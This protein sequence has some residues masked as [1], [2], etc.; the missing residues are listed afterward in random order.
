MSRQ[1]GGNVRFRGPGSLWKTSWKGSVTLSQAC[2]VQGFSI[3]ADGQF[4]QNPNGVLDIAPASGFWLGVVVGV[5]DPPASPVPIARNGSAANEGWLLEMFPQN[6]VGGDPGVGFRFTVYDGS[7]P[8]AVV[9]TTAGYA[10]RTAGQTQLY[11]A[12][13]IIPVMVGLEPPSGTHTHGRA[14]GGWGGATALSAAYS[15]TSPLLLVGT[16]STGAY[17]D[18]IFGIVGGQ[19]QW[20]ENAGEFELLSYDGAWQLAMLEADGVVEVPDQSGVT[21]FQN[22]HG[23]RIADTG[24]QGIAAP[25]PLEDFVG[26]EELEYGNTGPSAGELTISCVSPFVFSPPSA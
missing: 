11:G 17:P 8:A 6:T 5:V 4:Y 24:P 18:C 26:N 25:N 9:S 23:W 22:L 15:N 1:A 14:I 16:D 20:T 12:T 19:A 13:Q 10:L 21:G 7:G 3:D 2:C